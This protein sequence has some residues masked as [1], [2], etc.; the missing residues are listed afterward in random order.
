MKHHH[1]NKIGFTLAEV[2][3]TL[4]IIGVV[5]A[6]TMPAIIANYQKAEALSKLKK[7]NSVIGQFLQQAEKD[8]GCLSDWDMVDVINTFIK[9]YFNVVSDSSNRN[10][11][12]Y[13]ASIGYS[14]YSSENGGYPRVFRTMSGREFSG[15][16]YI[17]V[18]F[19][20][21]DGILYGW[22]WHQSQMSGRRT[23]EILVDINGAKRPN[24]AGKDV[25]M[26]DIGG[27]YCQTKVL[28]GHCGG[29]QSCNSSG[30][31]KYTRR[32]SNTGEQCRNG[33]GGCATKIVEDG[34]Q[35]K[36]DYPW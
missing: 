12:T 8:Y 24:I 9:P 13:L 30:F 5:A 23:M 22:G 18:F 3:I 15:Y 32:C 6:L 29:S 20:T 28:P 14:T 35:I 33:G 2:L 1:K 25:F 27:A 17:D 31:C 16:D 19:Y 4:G 10:K 7:V 36:D 26:F 34:W 11:S 21:A